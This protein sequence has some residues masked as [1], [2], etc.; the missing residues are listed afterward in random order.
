M[1][2]NS[3]PDPG[4]LNLFLHLGPVRHHAAFIVEIGGRQNLVSQSFSP[5]LGF[6]ILVGSVVV[7][8]GGIR[9]GRTVVRAKLCSLLLG[10]WLLYS[11][12]FFSERYTRRRSLV[13]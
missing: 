8:G 2:S 3:D 6:L 13:F 1:A 4:C 9:D 10:R 5:G 12:S 11:T 7:G